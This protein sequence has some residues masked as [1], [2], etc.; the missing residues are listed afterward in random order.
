MYLQ[1]ITTQ[2]KAKSHYMFWFLSLS[3]HI[4]RKD[5]VIKVPC[6]ICLKLY[7]EACELFLDGVFAGGIDHLVTDLAII[8]APV[9]V[10][11]WYVYM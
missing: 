7:S 11:V 10:H 5:T 8:W 1:E 6:V 4:L 9:C 3:F 2:T